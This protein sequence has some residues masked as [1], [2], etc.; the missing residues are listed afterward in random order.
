MLL[1]EPR[2]ILRNHD[3]R[4]TSTALFVQSCYP[5]DVMITLSG[6]GII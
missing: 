2:E 3:A 6:I 5:V 1:L 4:A